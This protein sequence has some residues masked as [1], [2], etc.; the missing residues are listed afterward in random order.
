M[1]KKGLF[2][3]R[4]DKRQLILL[5]EAQIMAKELVAFWGKGERIL[6]ER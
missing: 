6:E 2:G 3:T 1:P 4:L 5:I